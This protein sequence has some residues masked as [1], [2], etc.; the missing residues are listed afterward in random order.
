MKLNLDTPSPEF[1]ADQKSQLERDNVAELRKKLNKTGVNV[2][3]DIVLTTPTAFNSVAFAKVANFEAVFTSSG[4]FIEIDF[5][6]N[7]QNSG[8]AIFYIRIIVDG[9]LQKSRTMRNDVGAANNLSA[10]VFYKAFLGEG[11]H[12]VEV[13]ASSNASVTFSAEYQSELTVKET[14]L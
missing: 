3:A 4:G 13:Q 6:A 7:L 11:R 5:Q 10:Y 12:R 9:D 2:L 1:D 14:I 8:S